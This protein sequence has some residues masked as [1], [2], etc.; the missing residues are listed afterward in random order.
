LSA[1]REKH[2]G[3]FI[4]FITGLVVFA[5]TQN[6]WFAS[7]AGAFVWILVDAFIAAMR[8]TPKN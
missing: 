4:G 5:T 6:I 7:I 1:G 2:V 8:G 3:H